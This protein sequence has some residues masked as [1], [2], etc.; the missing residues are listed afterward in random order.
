MERYIADTVEV[1]YVDKEG[2]FS[3]RT[4]TVREVAGGW[5]SAFCHARGAPRRFRLEQVL[6]VRPVPHPR[7]IAWRSVPSVADQGKKTSRTA[8]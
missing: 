4:I 5:V 2:R 7:A 3:Q 8:G 6:A 1:I